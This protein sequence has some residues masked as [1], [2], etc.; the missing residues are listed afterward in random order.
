MK[1]L[2]DLKEKV[3]RVIKKNKELLEENSDLRNQCKHLKDQN[4]QMKV[5]LMKATSSSTALSQEH[6]SVKNSIHDLLAS[7][8]SL[9]SLSDES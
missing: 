4:E 2:V 1:Q 3:T 5:S 8:N 9:D 7:L 6:E